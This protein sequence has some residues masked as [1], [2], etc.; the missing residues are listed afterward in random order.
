[1]KNL[2]DYHGDEAI[3]L[4]A[5]LLDPLAAIISDDKIQKVIRSGKSRMVIAQTILKQH[6]KEASEILTR[7][8][9]TPIDGL[10]I[11]TR[12]ISLITDI[13]KNDE[14]KS[15]FAY[16]EQANKKK[17]SSGSATENT[18]GEEK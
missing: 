1:M 15:F 8:D 9:P 17:E 16:A 11:V 4:W 2:T 3:E 6:K 14:I 12:L 10:N 5:D 7:I 18:E 13:G